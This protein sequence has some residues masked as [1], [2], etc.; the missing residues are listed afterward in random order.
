MWLQSAGPA[1]KGVPA[2][3]YPIPVC[4]LASESL[5]LQ[6]P[7][8]RAQAPPSGA[9]SLGAGLSCG[10]LGCNRWDTLSSLLSL[11]EAGLAGGLGQGLCAA[12]G[13]TEEGGR[14]CWA[15]L[16]SSIGGTWPGLL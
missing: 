2:P 4:S 15:R 7:H 5:S 8:S 6:V 13:A 10:G 12:Q 14:A 11:R 3:R 1:P 16:G 9:L